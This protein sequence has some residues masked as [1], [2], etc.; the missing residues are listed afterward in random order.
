M[1]NV[2]LVTVIL[3]TYNRE[4]QIFY[5]LDSLLSSAYDKL[6]I[7]IIDDGSTDK[8]SIICKEYE[9]MDSRV[10]YIHQQNLG[11][12]AA[13]NTGLELAK[14]EWITFVDSD[15]VIL[16]HHYDLVQ[17]YGNSMY[18][19]LLT[20]SDRARVDEY[21][22]RFASIATDSV[23]CHSNL[24]D[25]IFGAY[26]PYENGTPFVWNKIFR[27]SIIADNCIRFDETMSM[28]E[29]LDFVCKYLLYANAGVAYDSSPSY[30]T[31][32]WPNIN[33]LGVYLRT[34]NNYLYNIQQCYNTLLNLFH[35]TENATVLQ[36][37]VTFVVDR[38]IT[39]I[40][41]PYRKPGNRKDVTTRALVEF[42]SFNVRRLF[43]QIDVTV[44]L[45]V[46]IWYKLVFRLIRLGW[47]KVVIVIVD[48]VLWIKRIKAGQR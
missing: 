40:V 28:D 9:N 24:V 8:T 15:D 10:R 13:R 22:E 26:N 4:S 5:C 3:P 20:G 39:R 21:K 48:T 38:T 7:L 36:Y 45:R 12:S 43:N 42:L 47:P 23:I 46:S 41:V 30:L 44:D 29:D 25:Y 19:L 34:P 6:E 31:L 1:N 18:D 33:H 11:V 37:A 17:K 32:Y 16:P 14:G 2:G 35:R 27:H